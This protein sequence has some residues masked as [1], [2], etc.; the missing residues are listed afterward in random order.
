LVTEDIVLKCLL[1]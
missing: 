1:I